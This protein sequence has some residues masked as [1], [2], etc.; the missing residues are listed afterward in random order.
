MDALGLLPAASRAPCHLGDPRHPGL[1]RDG[2]CERPRLPGWGSG[3]FRRV[4]LAGVRLH[5]PLRARQDVAAGRE[6]GGNPGDPNKADP[7][8]FVLWQPSA[9]GEPA[10][11][12][13]W[14]RGRPGWHI[15][16]SALAVRELGVTIDL[17]GGGSDLIFPHHECEAAQSEAATGELFVRHWVHTGMVRYEGIKMSKSLG[18]PRVR[19]GPA[20]RPGSRQPSASPSLPTTTD[21]T[22][23]GTR[24]CSSKLPTGWPCGASTLMPEDC[25]ARAAWRRALGGGGVLDEVRAALDD[26]LST[27]RALAAIDAAA[28]DAAGEGAR[29]A[30]RGGGRT[31]R[32]T[33]LGSPGALTRSLSLA[34]CQ[35]PIR[36]P[37]R[38]RYPSPCPTAKPRA[39]GGL[40]WGGPRCRD[41]PSSGPGCDRRSRQTGPSATSGRYCPTVRR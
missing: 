2:A 5:Q 8:D 14:G 23:T 16:C 20:Q 27:P 25:L 19:E 11:D 39:A 1:H 35:L 28:S 4:L 15:E 38:A 3:L 18:Q 21:R 41:R 22:G 32:R 13:L 34:G 37:A 6:R 36:L 12:S 26:D 30:G 17:H 24:G 40:N 9:P 10:W 33:A 7:L 31:T 29:S